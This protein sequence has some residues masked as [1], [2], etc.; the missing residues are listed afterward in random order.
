M[1]ADEPTGNLDSEN[2]ARALALLAGLARDGKTVITVSH[3]RDIAA[4]F[5]RVV[6]L[7]DG[8]IADDS[9]ARA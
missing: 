6:T 5:A 8:R 9:G 7:R 3:E 2:S 1:I 4:H